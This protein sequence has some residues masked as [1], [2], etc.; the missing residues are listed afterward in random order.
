MAE[1]KDK[2][3]ETESSNI[4][5]ILRQRERLEQILQE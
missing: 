3:A 4:E 1:D 5:E 2:R